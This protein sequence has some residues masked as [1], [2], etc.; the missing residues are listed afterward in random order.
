MD[1]KGKF[2]NKSDIAR[3]TGM[4]HRT[5]KRWTEDGT[6]PSP[7]IHGLGKRDLWTTK[8]IHAWWDRIGDRYAQTGQY[9][10]S[11]DIDA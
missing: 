9:R 6:L 8:Q 2:Y 5:I 10:T 7:A 4:S 3:F 11:S 1:D